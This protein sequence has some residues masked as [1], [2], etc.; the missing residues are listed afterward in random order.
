MSDSV[1]I[2]DLTVEYGSGDA[3]LRA[4]S[5]ISVVLEPSST[6]CVVGGSGAGKSTLAM[7]VLG[8]LPESARWAGDVSLPGN[9]ALSR[10]GSREVREYRRKSVGVVFQDAPGSLIP[11]VPIGKQVEQAFRFRRQMSAATAARE[12]RRTLERVGL[13]DYSRISKARSFELSGGMCQRVVI[14]MALAA[15][16]PLHL[17]LADEAVSN[18]DSVS[19]AQVLDL[20]F[21]LQKEHGATLI[22]ITHDARL[23]PRFNWV[24]VLAEGRVVEIRESAAFLDHPSSIEGQRLLEASRAL[25]Q[26]MGNPETKPI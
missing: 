3:R 7:A 14:A 17:L 2:R 19:A 15:P 18:L 8:L 22:F 6:V 26:P 1:E 16:G 5:N 21:D 9:F 11:G 24:C 13:T 20:I 10:S 12:A 23:L 25:G 4:L